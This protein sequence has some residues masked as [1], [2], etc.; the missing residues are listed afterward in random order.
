MSDVVKDLFAPMS[1]DQ[2]DK[3]GSPDL[4]E[5]GKDCLMFVDGKWLEE[6][7]TDPIVHTMQLRFQVDKDY[8]GRTGSKAKLPTTL[9]IDI[10]AVETMENDLS[11]KR[12][13][14]FNMSMAEL[15][16]I[17]VAL[18]GGNPYRKG[19]LGD[20]PLNGDDTPMNPLLLVRDNVDLL[21]NR[22]VNVVVDVD[23]GTYEKNGVTIQGAA[24]NTFTNWEAFEG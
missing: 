14:Q 17:T 16:R 4:L 2:F 9:W 3:V 12:T 6:N 23:D 19:Q 10:P 15:K 7:R 21:K 18:F 5:P 13:T 20:Y 1:Q 22:R 24:K 11:G 8:G